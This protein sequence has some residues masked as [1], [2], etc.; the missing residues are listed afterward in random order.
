MIVLQCAVLWRV[1]DA[2]CVACCCDVMCA[3]VGRATLLR[4]GA[5][6]CVVRGGVDRRGVLLNGALLCGVS[7]GVMLGG[8]CGCAAWRVALRCVV[9][10]ICCVAMAR[11]AVRCFTKRGGAL[12]RGLICGVAWRRVTWWVVVRC[13]VSRRVAPRRVVS[14]RAVPRRDAT[15]RVAMWRDVMCAVCVARGVLRRAWRAARRAAGASLRNVAW[16][17]L[18]RR[19]V[20]RRAADQRGA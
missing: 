17:G 14:H 15:R 7:R 10:L 13:G 12:R 1:L 5:W 18:A 16:R 20:L 9:V 19:G 2:A 6:P 11:V 4:G 8:A 3:A